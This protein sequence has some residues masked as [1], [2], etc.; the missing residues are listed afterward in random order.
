MGGQGA[1]L[2]K[3][4]YISSGKGMALVK[5][6]FVGAGAI[7]TR[8]LENLKKIGGVEVTAVCDPDQDALSRATGMT[9]ARGYRDLGTMLGEEE[10]DAAFVCVPTR[11][12]GEVEEA[13]AGR[14]IHL[15]IEKHIMCRSHRCFFTIINCYNLISIRK[16]CDHK[17][18]TAK[19]ASSR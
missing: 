11:A 17:T 9:G 12:H 8:H 19:I 1:G 2:N 3:P 6:A 4:V 7:A 15:F 5:L 14:G 10:I 13:L 18:A 16:V